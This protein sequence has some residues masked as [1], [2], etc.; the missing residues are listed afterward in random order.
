MIFVLRAKLIKILIFYEFCDENQI[1]GILI[2][3]E[4]FVL[5]IVHIVNK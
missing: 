5:H 4:M 3:H 1:N 2:F